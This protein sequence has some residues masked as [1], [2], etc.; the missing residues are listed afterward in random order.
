[1]GRLERYSEGKA[2]EQRLTLGRGRECPD[3]MSPNEDLVELETRYL[4]YREWFPL[5]PSRLYAY[6][7][8]P[9]RPMSAR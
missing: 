5:I 1:M 3:P 6:R 9:G 2:L 7:N 8:G 4:I